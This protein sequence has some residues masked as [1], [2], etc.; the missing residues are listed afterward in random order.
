MLT[1]PV[2]RAQ[3]QRVIRS[4][5]PYV[6]FMVW[7]VLA[8]HPSLFTFLSCLVRSAFLRLNAVTVLPENGKHFNN[9]WFTFRKYIYIFFLCPMPPHVLVDL[10]GMAAV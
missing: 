4:L 3:E 8:K 6:P 7:T 9:R 1:A 2:H 5:I 10:L